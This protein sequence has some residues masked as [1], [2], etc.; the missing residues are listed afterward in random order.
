MDKKYHTKMYRF[1]L[2]PRWIAAH[3]AIV[4]AGA[5]FVSLGFWQIDRLDQRRAEIAVIESQSRKAP[6]PLEQLLPSPA[7]SPKDGAR[8]AYRRA[9]VEGT[10]DSGREVLLEGRSDLGRPG[11]HLLTP[12]MIKSGL[13]VVVDRGWV[14]LELSEPPI[15][16]ARPP[17]GRVWVTGVLLPPQPRTGW[18]A[19]DPTPGPVSRVQT[20]DLARLDRQ[21]PYRVLPLVLQL[22][23]Q[24]P[25]NRGPLPKV[26][27]SPKP[28][29]GSHLS[30]AVQWFSFA[31]IAAVTYIFLIRRH[32]SDRAKQTD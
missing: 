20:V 6:A 9:T 29:E 19:K 21:L 24:V 17:G 15:A 28:D 27:A 23:E 30:Y 16:E 2:Q 8:Q 25:R 13:A 26:S 31:A 10:F 32:A 3:L 4:A 5:L 11:S 18:G 1:L 22:K 14:P 12:L 7:E